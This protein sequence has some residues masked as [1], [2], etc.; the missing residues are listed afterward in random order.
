MLQGDVTGEG[1][2]TAPE[3]RLATH[4]A[5]V[6]K[7][8]SIYPETNERVLARLGEFLGCLTAHQQRNAG[9]PG[10]DAERG[11]TIL[12]QGSELLVE[13]MRDAVPPGSSL[14][15]LRER[16]AHAG[17]AG[18]EMMPDLAAE[19]FVTFTKRLLANYLRKDAGLTFDDLWPDAYDGLVLI[20]RRF[21]G[22]FGGLSADGPFAGGHAG[23]AVRGANT[24]H[25]VRGLLAHPKV[26]K[27]VGKLHEHVATLEFEE[28]ADTV[29]TSD[30]IKRIL[31]DVPAEALKSRDALIGAVCRVMDELATGGAPSGALD[32]RG[33]P[34]DGSGEASSGDFASL[35]YQVSRTHFTRKGPGLERLRPDADAPPSLTPA[36]GRARDDD[37]HD[38]VEALAAELEGLPRSL[39]YDFAA[40]AAES[41]AEQLAVGLYFLVS[42]DRPQELPGLY[43]MLM[44]ALERADALSLTVLRGYLEG[45]AD[46]AALARQR[47]VVR[48]LLRAGHAAHLRQAGTLN[49]DFVLADPVARLPLL[50]AALDAEDP[51]HFAELNAVCSQLGY[52]LLGQEALL[53]PALADIPRD[54]AASVFLRPHPARLPLARL[55]LAAHPGR[56][57]PECTAFLRSIDLPEDEAFVLFQLHDTDCITR[58]YLCALM[59]LHLERTDAT[60]AHRTIVDLLCKH[61][62][63]TQAPLPEHPERLES[64]RSLARYP[65]ANGWAMLKELQK[66]RFG[67]FGGHE[68][69]TVRKLARSVAKQL[70]AFKDSKPEET[71]AAGASEAELPKPPAPAA[72]AAETTPTP[73]RV[74][75]HSEAA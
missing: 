36:G 69:A 64:I 65:S 67:P 10:H 28:H 59:D 31:D 45:G 63:A 3:L 74:D 71:P 39:G 27:R 15:W 47:V 58:A 22:T 17:L 66:T 52:G 57:V 23:T 24:S 42:L 30:L 4:W 11:V 19:D 54:R 33:L 43:P 49:P 29:R 25:F 6:S 75:E 37:I 1:Q 44:R 13:D 53:R 5:D 2:G 50:L 61:I 9:K 8:L 7:S 20:D 32:L 48:F 72:G 12:F 70:R 56:L 68:P 38:D 35:L 62:R 51:A 14:Q 34:S 18:V 46:E 21:E 41:T 73:A 60:A 40:G 55:L 16:I 26:A